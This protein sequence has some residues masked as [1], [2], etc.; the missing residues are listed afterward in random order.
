[1]DF[2]YAPEHEA[3]RRE[4][5]S[6]LAANLPPELCLDDAADDRV[7]SDRATFERRRAW[8]KTM[9]AAG[10]VGIS[11]PK[12]YGGRG[13]TLVERVI[14]DEEYTAARAPVLPGNMGLN[15]I[16][17]TIIQ[18]GTENQRRRYLPAILSG[19]EV[20]CQG[21]SEPGAGSDL[22]ALSTRAVDR[23]DHF[24]VNGQKVWTSG[25]QYAH[26]ILL[27]ARTDPE[28]PKHQG[29]SML[30]VPMDTRGITV[31]P[32]VLMTGHPHFNEVFFSD[33][34]VP[35]TQLLGPLNRGWKVATTTLMHERHSAGARN[36]IGQVAAL[37]SAALRLRV[38]GAAAA[39]AITGWD[40][41]TARDGGT[42]W[43]DPRVR[44]RLAQLVIDC[45]AMRYTRYRS[46][47]RQFRGEPPGPEGSILKLFG[48][49]LG[50]RIADAA[51]ELLGMHALVNRPSALIPDAPRW[52]NRLLAARQYTISAGTS[53]IQRNI[54]GERVLGLPKG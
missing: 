30:L 32:L 22:A 21:F 46:L 13:A 5:R 39:D 53:E 15:L 16:G 18:W 8:Q 31:R 44:Q 40:G 4:F 35:K 3:F 48:S 25:A 1:M 12:E 17:P 20:W 47:T 54:I 2:E 23:G 37:V 45:E 9:H 11:W 14:W 29:L 38:D 19:D 28:L 42:A 51:G 50:V 36:P 26:W 27:L 34:V 33:V 41:G 10:W 7:A 49:E 52:F 24:V 6:W 43:D